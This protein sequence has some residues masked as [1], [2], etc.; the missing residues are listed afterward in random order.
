MFEAAFV[1]FETPHVHPIAL[2]P[3]NEL[4]AVC[5]TADYS[6]EVFQ[7]GNDGIPTTCFQS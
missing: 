2:N 7:F 3:D 6:V 4:L 1:N 5:N